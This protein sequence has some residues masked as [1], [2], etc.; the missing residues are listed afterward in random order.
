MNFYT[1]ISLNDGYPT[2]MSMGT[3]TQ[4]LGYMATK[5]CEYVA[6]SEGEVATTS[7][8]PRSLQVGSDAA[9][10]SRRRLPSPPYLIKLDATTSVR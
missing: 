7:P 4:Y 5:K 3:N 9:F 10:P 1:P 8:R 6:M 2:E